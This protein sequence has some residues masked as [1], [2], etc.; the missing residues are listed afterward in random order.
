MFEHFGQRLKRDL[1]NIVDKR[2]ELSEMQSGTALRVRDN[3]CG[4]CSADMGFAVH[5][6]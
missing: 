1:K 4:I 3:H 5:W 6:R 2:I